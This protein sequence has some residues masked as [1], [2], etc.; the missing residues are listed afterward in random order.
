MTRTLAALATSV[1]VF[2]PLAA[3]ADDHDDECRYSGER[4]EVLRVDGADE[5]R[6]EAEAGFLRVIGEPGLSEVVLDG[7]ACAS[8]EEYLDEIELRTGR[9][10]SSL[11]VD[12]ELPNID[13]GWNRYARLDLTVRVP[14][15]M[16]LDI[17]DGSGSIEIEGAGETR[18]EDGS[19]SIE[20]EDLRGDLT[21]IDGSGSI[22]VRDI[23]GNLTVDEDGSGSMQI[24]GVTGNVDIDEDGSGSITIRD[25][26]GSVRIREDGSGSI[27]AVEVVGDFVVDRDGSGG[28]SVDGIGGR[29][30]IPD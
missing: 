26:G 15:E 22:D 6:L 9:R 30:E 19:G 25:V 29:I 20:I 17:E 3:L 21:L 4:Q 27:R 23:E 2:A 14:T 8:R 10:G 24:T 28:I 11:I 12:V 1:L 5:L 13:W 18:V 7:T 16:A